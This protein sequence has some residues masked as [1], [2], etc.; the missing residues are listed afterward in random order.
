M[1]WINNK[2]KEVHH[3]INIALIK[4]WEEDM[5]VNKHNM[6]EHLNKIINNSSIKVV[7][8]HMVNNNNQGQ[9]K[10]NNNQTQINHN[11][12]PR[13]VGILKVDTNNLNRIIH[14]N[15]ITCNSNSL[16]LIN[17]NSTDKIHINSSNKVFLLNKDL[18]ITLI[19]HLL[20]SSMG[21]QENQTHQRTWRW[22]NYL[23]EVSHNKLMMVCF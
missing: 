5:K 7:V 9:D 6:V 19:D 12:E 13:T 23:L 1:E 15:K 4:V 14:I 11:M 16:I 18:T 8:I 20:D 3:Q 10:V 21:L 17:N 22:G 2:T